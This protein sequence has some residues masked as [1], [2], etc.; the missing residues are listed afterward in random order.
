VQLPRLAGCQA[1]GLGIDKLV[2]LVQHEKD[3]ADEIVTGKL[4]RAFLRRRHL[5]RYRLDTA[6]QSTIKYDGEV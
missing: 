4:H 2:E 3:S 1:G 5:S 6:V